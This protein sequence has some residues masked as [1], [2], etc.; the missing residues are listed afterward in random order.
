MQLKAQDQKRRRGA[1]EATFATLRTCLLS[2]PVKLSGQSKKTAFHTRKKQ[3]GQVVLE[4]I[5]LLVISVTAATYLTRKLV[6]RNPDNPGFITGA[7]SQINSAI[8]ADIVD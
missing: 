2:R 3:S 5:L 4:Y 7:W 8:G 6:G 1:V